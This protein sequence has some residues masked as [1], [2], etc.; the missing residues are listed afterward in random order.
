MIALIEQIAL[1]IEEPGV[2]SSSACHTAG[3]PHG[4]SLNRLFAILAEGLAVDGQ[5]VLADQAGL[6]SARPTTA[7]TPPARWKSSPRIFAGRLQVDQQRNFVARSSPN[8]RW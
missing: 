7:G 4:R 1:E 6:R 8:R 5:R 3:S 2:R